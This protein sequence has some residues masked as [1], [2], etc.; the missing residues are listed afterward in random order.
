VPN[1]QVFDRID[2]SLEFSVEERL[3]LAEV[4][5]ICSR[6]IAPHAAQYDREASFPQ[7][8]M[9]AIH[10]LGLNQM[11]IPE[12]CG[13]APMSY[14]AYLLAVREI[15]KACASTGIIW[16][17]NFHGMKPLIDFGTQA[18]ATNATTRDRSRRTWRFSDY[19]ARGRF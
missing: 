4:K 11:F 14:T 12:D 15:S 7:R 17:T 5:R 1:K 3:L 10:Q 6:E 9:D 8:S 19:R 18:L 16:A 13:G 2:Q